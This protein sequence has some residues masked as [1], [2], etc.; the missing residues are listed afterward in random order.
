MTTLALCQQAAATLYLYLSCNPAPRSH[1]LD[2]THEKLKADLANLLAQASSDT[3]APLHTQLY[4]CAV[5]PFFVAA[6]AKVGWD[7]IGING[8][9]TEDLKRLSA[10]AKKIQSRPLAVAADVLEKVKLERA[11]RIDGGSSWKWDDAFEGRCSFCV[12]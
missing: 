5:W 4:K 12:L 8:G 2:T 3:E 7:L 10:V 6:Y 9:D 11:R 1:F